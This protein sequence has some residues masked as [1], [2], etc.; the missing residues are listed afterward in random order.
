MDHG[1]ACDNRT[2][3]TGSE[4]RYSQDAWITVA[5]QTSLGDIAAQQ[6][7]HLPQGDLNSSKTRHIQLKSMSLHHGDGLSAIRSPLLDG[8]M[9]CS[10]G[11]CPQIQVCFPQTV[12]FQIRGSCQ[13]KSA[14]PRKPGSS[15]ARGVW[16]TW[17]SGN[18]YD[19]SRFIREH[20]SDG[21]ATARSW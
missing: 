13:R 9:D 6:G 20:R 7:I 2:S 11:L 21:L 19:G 17:S 3:V 10:G 4:S 16:Y 14:K 5:S 8:R 1:S 18:S 15:K 12:V